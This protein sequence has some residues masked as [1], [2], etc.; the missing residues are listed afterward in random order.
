MTG[1]VLGKSRSIERLVAIAHN[2]VLPQYSREKQSRLDIVQSAF[3][4]A[5]I[6]KKRSIEKS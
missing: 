4:L 5:H 3:A 1:H 6:P 2:T